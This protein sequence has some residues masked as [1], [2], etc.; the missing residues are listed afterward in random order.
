MKKKVIISS[1][2]VLVILIGLILFFSFG[3]NKNSIV[4]T[5]TL[6]INPSVEL[7]LDKENKIVNVKALN[8]D[9]KKI[10]SDKLV[11]K[12]L[13]DAITCI[14]EKVIEEDY[15]NDTGAT[16]VMH[17]EGKIKSTQVDEVLKREFSKKN[18]HA[19]VIVVNSITKE[20]KKLAEKYNV[21]PAKAAYINSLDAKEN[22]EEL[23]SKS[24]AE[25]KEIK[26]TNQYCEKGYTLEHGICYKQVGEEEPSLGNVC[27]EGYGD[28][29]GICYEETTIIE[30]SN[31][32]CRGEFVLEDGKC[33]DKEIKDKLPI[34]ECT[35]GELGKKG[36]YYTIGIKDAEKMVCV[37]KSNAKKP[38][39]RCLTINHIMIN[40]ECYVGPAPTI[41]GG[42]PNGDTLSG[43][44]CYSKDNG[45][46][47]VCPNG[48]IYHVSQNAVPD[49]CPDTFK[50]TDPKITGY[51]CE[52]GYTL[53]NDKC[54]KITTQDAEFERTCKDGYTLVNNSKCINKNNTKPY[55]KG[56]V[57][58]GE[59]AKLINNKC[60]IYNIKEPIKN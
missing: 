57:C 42:C 47:W 39:L 19:E 1:C 56:D 53:E 4:S 22:K 60:I 52:D 43:G 36:D 11:G 28:I 15:I 21:S 13:D 44:G 48:G 45:D 17:A 40:G 55:K 34:Y 18:I 14:A 37:D 3:K 41:N 6:D 27:P 9:A 32:V 26:D 38:T 29:D 54:I 49:L 2:A 35:S 7:N 23:F 20:D 5:I 8:D 46:Q 51:K 30:T 31:L 16:I 50:Y 12:F 58:S 24:V 33:V 10:V 59:N 25:I